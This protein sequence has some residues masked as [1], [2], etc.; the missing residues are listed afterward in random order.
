MSTSVLEENGS[1]HI[2]STQ[3]SLKELVQDESII[4]FTE[5][6]YIKV[7]YIADLRLLNGMVDRARRVLC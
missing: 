3:K 6:I 7:S 5:Q 2:L 1:K 4:C